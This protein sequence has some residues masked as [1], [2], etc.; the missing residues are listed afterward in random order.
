[1]QGS[2]HTCGRVLLAVRGPQQRGAECECAGSLRQG[3][4]C[5]PRSGLGT[6]LNC[7]WLAFYPRE[8]CPAGSTQWTVQ[9]P[10]LGEKRVSLTVHLNVQ[11]LMNSQFGGKI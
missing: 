7:S 10:E 8:L 5:E 4:A 9:M 1:M 11:I 3:W 6:A 2:Y